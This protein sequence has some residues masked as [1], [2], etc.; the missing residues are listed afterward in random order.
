MFMVVLME[1]LFPFVLYVPSII[2]F[3]CSENLVSPSNANSISSEQVALKIIS[4]SLLSNV[5]KV[6]AVLAKTGSDTLTQ[7]VEP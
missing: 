3:G 1:K 6:T 4:D 7:S 2:Y 5:V